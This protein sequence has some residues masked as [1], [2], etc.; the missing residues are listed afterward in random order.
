[1]FEQV[2]LMAAPDLNRGMSVLGFCFSAF[3]AVFITPVQL[4]VSW[5]FQCVMQYVIYK[6]VNAAIAAWL[7]P[8]RMVGKAVHGAALRVFPDLEPRGESVPAEES[9]D[10]EELNELLLRYLNGIDRLQPRD[11]FTQY[12]LVLF[13]KPQDAYYMSPLPFLYIIG[14]SD[15]S[16][17]EFRPQMLNQLYLSTVGLCH[18]D[19]MRVVLQAA[20]LRTPPYPHK[21]ALQ[22]VRE[23]L[24]L[25][26]A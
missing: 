7:Y 21:A 8:I 10:K 16:L 6:C 4:A 14:Q 25:L 15:G 3:V 1:M 12:K 18:L 13:S 23:R 19:P 20:P 2:I 24:Q 22:S 17:E 5:T 26:E 11:L 9:E